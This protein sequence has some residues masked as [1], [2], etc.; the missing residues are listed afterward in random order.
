MYYVLLVSSSLQDVSSNHSNTYYI[1]L[2]VLYTLKCVS[3]VSQHAFRLAYV[4]RAFG[5]SQP[6]ECVLQLLLY[7][8]HIPKRLLHIEMCIR[9]IKTCFSCST[10]FMCFWCLPVIQNVFSIYCFIWY[11]FPNV[12]HTSKCVSRVSEHVSLYKICYT[13]KCAAQCVLRAT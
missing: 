7:L 3:G 6:S 11:I 1:F 8:L 5:V 12:Y 10:C 2:N 9:C 4:R 13:S